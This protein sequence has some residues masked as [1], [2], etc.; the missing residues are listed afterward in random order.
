MNQ[1]AEARVELIAVIRTYLTMKRMK[2]MK[3]TGRKRIIQTM[4][5]C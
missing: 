2:K 4:N 1:E 3:I 5:I